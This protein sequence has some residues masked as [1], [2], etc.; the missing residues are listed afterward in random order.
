MG[1]DSDESVNDQYWTYR[2]EAIPEEELNLQ[3]GE[4]VIYLCHVSIKDDK[5]VSLLGPVSAS[6]QDCMIAPDK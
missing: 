2:A 5:R 4:Q 1:E 6:P 3:E